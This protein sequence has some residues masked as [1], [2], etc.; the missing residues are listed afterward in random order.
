MLDDTITT[1][2][3]L[4][5]KNPDMRFIHGMLAKGYRDLAS[6]LRQSG[7]QE[8]AAKAER[9]AEEHQ[10]RMRGERPGGPGGNPGVS[11]K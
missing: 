8:P 2:T 10:A 1:L 7:E 6:M 11:T 9:K 5:D 3:G 4:L